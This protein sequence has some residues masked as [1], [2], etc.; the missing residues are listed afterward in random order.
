VLSPAPALET[1]KIELRAAKTA[2]A[3]AAAAVVVVARRQPALRGGAERTKSVFVAL[4]S[5]K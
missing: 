2:T 4:P 3:A 1:S 5:H